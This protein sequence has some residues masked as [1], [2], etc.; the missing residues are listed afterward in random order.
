MEHV[1]LSAEPNLRRPVLLY[2]FTGW[3]DAGDAASTAVR[4]MLAQ[5]HA[6]PLGEIDPEPFTD[7]ATVRPSVYLDGGRR[8]IRW[9]S[10]RLWSASLPGTD[11]I[12]LLGPEP[13]LRWRSFSAQVV[14]LA[15]HFGAA[16]AISLGALL[17]DYPHTHPVQVI[18]TATDPDLIDRFE[19]RPS[20]YE[21]PTGILGVLNDAFTSAGRPAASLWAT[22]P[23]Y[24]AQFPSPRACEALLTTACEMVGTAPP[25]G[26][27]DAAIA[28]YD[29]RVAA[30][31]ADNDDLAAY[32]TRLEAIMADG[33]DDGG[34]EEDE[35]E[36]DVD[37]PAAAASLVEEVER[38][39]KESGTE[40]N[41][42][43]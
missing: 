2:A 27:F 6:S 37:D 23:G 1:R 15:E 32:V 36:D 30:M 40:P 8:A 5:W 25:V 38:F 10:V 31:V 22:V 28:E 42:P 3:N 16:M 21:G 9:P 20:T 18:G 11:A 4:T 13:A 26:A 35:D 17:A 39:L 14:G 19:L 34:E 29:A 24:A 33:D 43:D 7:F 12:L 41:N